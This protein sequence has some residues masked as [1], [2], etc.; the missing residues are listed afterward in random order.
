M[1][2]RAVLSRDARFA[3]LAGFLAAVFAPMIFHAVRDP[4]AVMEIGFSVMVLHSLRWDD[5]LDKHSKAARIVITAMWL[6]NSVALACS[7]Y[8]HSYWAVFV[9][10]VVV[11]IG[12]LSARW[13][14]GY[15]AHRFVGFAAL[16]AMAIPAVLRSADMV[17]KVPAG[18]VVLLASFVLFA[19]GIMTALLRSRWLAKAADG[20][21]VQSL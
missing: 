20:R 10:G 12:A 4:F 13:V 6:I 16:T 3:L 7:D 2:S 19:G 1:F 15:W 17:D 11:F 8:P 9:S 21:I 18:L 5:R 14:A